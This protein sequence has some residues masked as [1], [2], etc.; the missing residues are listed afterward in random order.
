MGTTIKTEKIISNLILIDKLI[1]MT[2]KIIVGNTLIPP[3]S[4]ANNNSIRKF[5]IKRA[6]A[7]QKKIIMYI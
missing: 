5:K 3:N 7:L 1:M 6:R 2:A 4:T